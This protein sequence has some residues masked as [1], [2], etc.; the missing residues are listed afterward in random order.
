MYISDLYLFFHIFMYMY[1]L[2]YCTSVL[3][4]VSYQRVLVE[5]FSS[6]WALDWCYHRWVDGEL[7]VVLLV[8]YL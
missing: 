5:P 1:G 8:S 6:L 4:I 2:M 3:L 7:S